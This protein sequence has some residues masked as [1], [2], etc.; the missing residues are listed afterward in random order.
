MKKQEIAY[1]Y[2]SSYHLTEMALEI[3]KEAQE[4]GYKTK[5][6]FKVWSNKKY[7]KVIILS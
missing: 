4:L 3:E 1:P 5:I 7:A 6:E 2:N